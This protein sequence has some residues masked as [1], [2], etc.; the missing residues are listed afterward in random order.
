MSSPGENLPGAK[1]YRRLPLEPN[2][3]ALLAAIVVV[4][5]LTALLDQQHDYLNRP[6][7]S[8]VNVLRRTSM[9]GIFALGSAIVI[10]SG[11]IDL[12]S[13]SAIAFCGTICATVMLI[14]APQEMQGTGVPLGYGV[15]AAGMAGALAAG[16]LVGSLHAWLITVIGLPPFV[17]TLATLV[18]L[19]SL[20]RAIIPRATEA[21]LGSPSNQIQIFDPQ[22]RYLATA[23]WAWI[24]LVVFLTL[25][26]VAWVLL[27]RTV[28]GRHIYALGGNEEAARLSGIRTDRLKWLAYCTSALLAAVAG[29]LY[30]AEQSVADPQ[31][32]GR[33]YELNA[34]AAAVVG[35]CSLRGGVGTVLGTMLGCLFLSTVIDSVYKIIPS[36]ADVYEGLIVGVVVVVAVAF[37]QLRQGVVRRRTFFPGALGAVAAV[38]LA[39]LAGTVV[40]VALSREAFDQAGRYI[41]P[42]VGIVVLA[43]IVVV[44]L[45]ER[46]GA[47]PARG[48]DPR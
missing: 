4:V 24:P 41:G 19:R 22:F 15:I 23:P 45:F 16:F 47:N 17:A 44:K 18:G 30:I 48:D 34:I 36:G 46:R 11:G 9:L 27:D 37:S 6:L 25:S 35:G 40:T 5:V 26:L 39:L 13:G 42:A 32:L 20:A 43:A 2:E 21:M 12:S 7:D 10:I 3:L 29:V 33:A 1:W 31:T 14:L 8:L 38:M 28:M